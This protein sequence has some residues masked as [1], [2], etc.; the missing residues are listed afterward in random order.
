MTKRFIGFL[1]LVSLP[2]FIHGQKKS[3]LDQLKQNIADTLAMQKGFFAVAFKDLASG[4]E[5]LIN[6]H[7]RF[8]A[9]STMKT[10]VMIEVFKQAAARKFSLTDSVMLKNEFKSIIDGS[11]YKLNPADDSEYELYKHEGEKR[12]VQELLLQM[13]TVSS[14]FATNLLISLVDARNVNHTMRGLGAKDIQVLRGVEDQKAFDNGFNNVTTAHDLML[15]FTAIARG[16]AVG[17]KASDSMIHILLDQQFNEIIP[18]KL[19]A[20]VKV[21]H[22]T[23]FITGLQH[24]SGIVYLP[25]G[26]KYVLVLLSKNLEDE[27]AAIDA[28][29]TVSGMIYRYVSKK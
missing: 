27:P 21:A 7:Q 4:S 28:M 24:D 10:P 15:I 12:T 25:G 17:K 3:L 23:G 26:K 13:I 20:V 19:P 2:F 1:V 11:L 9:A 16:R 5:L 18:A 22:K 8:H 29:A 14:N 6:A